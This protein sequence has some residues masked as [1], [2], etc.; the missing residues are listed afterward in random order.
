MAK[1]CQSLA[2]A[3]VRRQ[4]KLLASQLAGVRQAE[5]IEFIHQ[6][7]VASRRLRTALRMFCGCFPAN[8]IKPWRSEIQ[9]V[10]RKLGPA[11]PG[12]A[13]RISLRHTFGSDR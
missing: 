8:Q 4:A 5:E 7:R 3:Y 11:R 10:A 6:A 1:N 13:N 2:G 9:R 12:C